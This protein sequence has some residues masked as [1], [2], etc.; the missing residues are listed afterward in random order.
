MHFPAPDAFAETM[1]E[2]GITD[3]VKY[4]LTFGITW[5]HIGRKKEGSIDK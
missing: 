4:P 2:A 1:E 3:V 5:L